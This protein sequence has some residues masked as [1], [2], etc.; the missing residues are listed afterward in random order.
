[1]RATVR[2]GATPAD[3]LE[4]IKHVAIYAGA[5]RALAASRVAKRVLAEIA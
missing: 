3:V 2:T 1:M 5:P 4:V